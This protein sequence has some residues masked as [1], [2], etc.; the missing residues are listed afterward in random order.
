MSLKSKQDQ[1]IAKSFYNSTY[2]IEK[3]CIENRIT[4]AG[5]NR[6]SKLLNYLRAELYSESQV[7][8]KLIEEGFDHKDL[9]NHLSSTENQN[10]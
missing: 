9:Q 1:Q 4:E 8:T 5:Y 10:Y 2:N 3:S 6:L 7:V